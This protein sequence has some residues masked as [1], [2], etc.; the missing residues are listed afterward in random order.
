MTFS[1][2]NITLFTRRGNT[3]TNLLERIRTKRNCIIG[4]SDDFAM[5]GLRVYNIIMVINYM[6]SITGYKYDLDVWK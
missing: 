3:H 5:G 1:G 2:I 4:T 6:P